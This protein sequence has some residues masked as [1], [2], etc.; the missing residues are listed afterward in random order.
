MNDTNREHRFLYRCRACGKIDDST[1]IGAN[2][3]TSIFRALDVLLDTWDIY[4]HGAGAPKM[5]D[6]HHCADGI[7]VGVSD[8]IGMREHVAPEP[9][10]TPHEDHCRKDCGDEGICWAPRGHSGPCQPVPF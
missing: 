3:G 8:F 2:D 6:L 5:L 9:A 1:G 7:T 4:K 10:T